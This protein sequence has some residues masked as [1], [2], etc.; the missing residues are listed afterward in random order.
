ML[1]IACEFN[2]THVSQPLERVVY[3][4]LFC[5]RLPVILKAFPCRRNHTNTKLFSELIGYLLIFA[6]WARNFCPALVNTATQVVSIGTQE[7]VKS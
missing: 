6:K 4:V 5:H 1:R 3:F 2:I 7:E